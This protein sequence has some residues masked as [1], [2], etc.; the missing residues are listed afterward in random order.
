[1]TDTITQMDKTEFLR[2]L[3][4]AKNPE[5]FVIKKGFY[6]A[7]VALIA[8]NDITNIEFSD[9]HKIPT[10]RATIFEIRNE[11]PKGG[12]LLQQAYRVKYLYDSW[13]GEFWREKF[14][15]SGK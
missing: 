2:L 14:T 11:K 1:M 9:G 4:K 13:A 5:T 3:D 15:T 7:Y 6:T 10:C 8:E 12:S